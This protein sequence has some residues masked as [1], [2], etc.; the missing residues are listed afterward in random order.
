MV[1][2]IDTAA[3]RKKL[4]PRRNPYYMAIPD[5]DGAYVGFRRGPDTW[6][7]RLREDGVQKF[8]ALGRF[9]DHRAAIREAKD[10]IKGRMVGV[11]DHSATVADACR[12]Y[13]SNLEK[14]KGRKAA[15][16]ARGRLQRRILGRTA[17]EARKARARPLDAHNLARKE[18]RKLRAVDI[19]GWRDELVPEGLDGEALRKARASANRE[20][21]SLVAALNHAFKR[22]MVQSPIAWATVSK[23]SDVQARRHRRHV[24]VDERKA[25]LAA[26]AKVET[27]A[28]RHLLEGLILTGAR[29]IELARA[30]VADYDPA[31][32]ALTLYSFKGKS[33]EPRTREVPLRALGGAEI[34]I[35]SR[36]KG[37]LPA[38]PIFTRD[39][40]KPWGHSDWDH[41]VREARE[42]AKIKPLTAYDL[43]HT[44]IT[45]ALT[46]GV[47]GLT[48]A[49]IVG[50]SLEMITR[51]Y[52]K[53][54]H[55]HAAT[56]FSNLRLL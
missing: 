35:K 47:D 6:I 19:E 2:R 25:L 42:A 3:A 43:R 54:L 51:T 13:I 52:G 1:E 37:K 48:V 22:Q 45:D 7:A 49:R 18:L 14:E 9:E 36:C 5:V 40:G 50:T 53:L 38:A 33:K 27:G 39:D 17:E 34:L 44:F 12:A 11:V 55:D 8:H 26:A 20:M 56:A 10:W 4:A 16:E 31:T 46:G 29:P 21:A 32:G 15:Q 24:T 28:I 30:T 41:L 23:F